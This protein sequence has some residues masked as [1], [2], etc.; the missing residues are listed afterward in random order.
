MTCRCGI[1]CL[2]TLY[3]R[4]NTKIQGNPLWKYIQAAQV[5]VGVISWGI[6]NQNDNDEFLQKIQPETFWWN[7]A[8]GQGSVTSQS[9]K[10]LQPSGGW[11]SGIR[12][13]K[14]PSKRSNISQ[15]GKEIHLQKYLWRHGDMLVHVA[16]EGN[17]QW[18]Y[19]VYFKNLDSGQCYKDFN[20][21]T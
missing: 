15:G 16:S 6:C 18:Q 2:Y 3:I 13:D 17:K 7:P 19:I 10:L 4:R 5:Q 20:M 1:N 11:W 8:L 9:F 12:M 21:S 14:A